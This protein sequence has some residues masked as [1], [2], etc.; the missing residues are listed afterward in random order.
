M[1]EPSRPQQANNVLYWLA[2]S[3]F[4]SFFNVRSAGLE[5]YTVPPKKFRTYQL[6]T[7]RW[8]VLQ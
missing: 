2:Y 7:M 6:L 4:F 3:V 1:L 8:I 5:P